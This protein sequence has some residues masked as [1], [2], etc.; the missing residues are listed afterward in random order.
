VARRGARGAV[1]RGA[2]WRG[3]VRRSRWWSPVVVVVV[4]VVVV[5]RLI[6]D[7]RA[8]NAGGNKSD[9]RTVARLRETDG[10]R[11]R[12]GEA[13]E[14]ARVSSQTPHADRPMPVRRQTVTQHNTALILHQLDRVSLHPPT[15]R[16]TAVCPAGLP[17]HLPPSS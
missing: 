11:E 9:A 16:S 2:A 12:Q 8:A 5:A 17:T 15:F 10:E 6:A 1:R 4:V 13:G 14:R 7:R 3:L